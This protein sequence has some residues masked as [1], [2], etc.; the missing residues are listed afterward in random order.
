MGMVFRARIRVFDGS[1]RRVKTW[2]RLECLGLDVPVR[3]RSTE[4]FVKREYCSI[5]YAVKWMLWV[6]KSR[7]MPPFHRV[8]GSE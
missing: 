6:R 3:G 4:S 5:H 2:P 7:E 8:L 1:A